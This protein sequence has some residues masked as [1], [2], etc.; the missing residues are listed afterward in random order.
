MEGEI[1]ILK[2]Q[3][4]NP[5]FLEDLLKYI[6]KSLLSSTLFCDNFLK[7][8]IICFVKL[9]SETV[10]CHKYTRQDFAQC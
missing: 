2:K 10:A 9:L 4:G 3:Q 8:T 6:T 7:F 1:K 5:L